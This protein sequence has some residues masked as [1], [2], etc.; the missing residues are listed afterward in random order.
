MK[1]VRFR[2]VT[3]VFYKTDIR[4]TPD[5]LVLAWW[6]LWLD[7]SLMVLHMC[8]ADTYDSFALHDSLNEVLS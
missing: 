7:R 3:M 1:C 8:F 4:E 2:Q 5:S 6:S